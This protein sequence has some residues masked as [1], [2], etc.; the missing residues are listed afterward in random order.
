MRIHE[1]IHIH[2]HIHVHVR[3]RSRVSLCLLCGAVS[4]RVSRVV[5]RYF[6]FVDR[7][8]SLSMVFRCVVLCCS[9]LLRADAVVVAA[10]CECM[11]MPHPSPLCCLTCWLLAGSSGN[12]RWTSGARDNPSPGFQLVGGASNQSIDKDRG[13][14][15]GIFR[16]PS[17][18]T[19]G[20]SFVRNIGE[21]STANSCWLSESPGVVILAPRKL[22]SDFSLN[23]RVRKQQQQLL[24]CRAEISRIFYVKMD[25]GS[26]GSCSVFRSLEK[27]RNLDW[28]R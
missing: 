8:W 28:W 6:L 18:W 13:L 24:I 4:R 16:T 21:P 2:A 1:H 11:R 25:L 27:Y 22:T 17:F 10:F 14:V 26:R 9:V 7:D 3:V 20:A 5:A 23:A 19:L 15:C 12:S